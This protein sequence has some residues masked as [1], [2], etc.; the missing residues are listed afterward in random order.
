MSDD[1]RPSWGNLSVL[2]STRG[3]FLMG[4]GAVAGLVFAAIGLFTAEGTTTLYVAPED[5]AMVNQQPISRSDYHAQIK[6]LFDVDYAQATPEQRKKAL[7]DMIREE[8]FV[9]RGNEIDVA[10]SD[11]TTRA[12][13]VSA[14]EQTAMTDAMTEVPSD[15]TLMA[16]YNAN[17]PRYSSEGYM[18][19]R[20]LV[21]AGGT[22]AQNLSAARALSPDQAIAKFGAKDSGKIAKDE[23]YFAADI[24]LG[25]ELSDKAKAL[26]DG[27]VSEPVTRPD[28]IHI[29]YMIKNVRPVAMDFE[30]A[31]SRI[32]TDYRR[33]K[34]KVRLANEE[35]FLKKRANIL[36]SEDMK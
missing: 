22:P 35:E 34:A 33:D 13:M 32:L 7:D 23:F 14:V 18:N 8:L 4:L 5:V 11:P 1:T 27:A 36:L 3:L 31:K 28:G 17:K 26:A 16:Y 25:K 20:D 10:V 29:V 24:H 19:L 9:Q 12:A 21:F 6:L 30:T 2:N 15:E